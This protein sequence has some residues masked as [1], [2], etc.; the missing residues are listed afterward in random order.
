M[1]SSRNRK[2]ASVAL[3]ALAVVGVR[4]ASAAGADLPGENIL[5]GNDGAT[6]CST[7]PI[8]IDYD[9]AYDAAL[10]GYAVSAA[11]LSGLDEHCAGY[12]AIVT[13]QG[14]GGDPLAELSDVVDGSDMRLVVPAG[15]P[16]SAAGL[17]GVSLVLKEAGA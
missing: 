11:R 9:V 8:T 14:P 2:A 17:T 5:V 4:F 12:D 6:D 16:V 13:L 7:A 3:A 10:R 15:S 1:L